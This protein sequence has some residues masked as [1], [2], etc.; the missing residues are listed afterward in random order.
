VF[1]AA[2]LF[3]RTQHPSPQ[4]LFVGLT[5]WFLYLYA[6]WGAAGLWS[7]RSFWSAGFDPFMLFLRSLPA[8]LKAL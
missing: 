7:G 6:V 1:G 5:A 2:F 4:R 3:S 8:L